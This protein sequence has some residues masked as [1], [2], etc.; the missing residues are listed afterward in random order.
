MF[1]SCTLEYISQSSRFSMPTQQNRPLSTLENW[2]FWRLRR[3][4]LCVL[5]LAYSLDRSLL[6]RILLY[7]V[8]LNH[9][10]SFY[11]AKNGTVEH[12]GFCQSTHLSWR[13]AL[14]DNEKKCYIDA[15]KCLQTIPAQNTSRP[16]SWTRFDEFQ[17]IH[18]E[19][20]LQI[21]YVV[22]RLN[23]SL[24]KRIWSSSKGQFLPWHRLFMK[25]YETALRNECGYQ[26][27]QP[28]VFS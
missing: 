10:N 6:R 7:G 22:C 19:L 26:G 4:W 27:A 17:A 2:W 8:T 16:A 23:F 28:C 5:F 13:R 21:H 24:P 20:A 18:I 25:S 1:Q 14:T 9:A 3:F 15:V 11:N 12:L